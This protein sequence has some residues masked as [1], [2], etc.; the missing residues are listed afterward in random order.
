MEGR[1]GSKPAFK[2]LYVAGVAAFAAVA[3]CTG[4]SN[5]PQVGNSQ[6]AHHQPTAIVEP[7][8]H[9]T[10]QGGSGSAAGA[11]VSGAQSANAQAATGI[12]GCDSGVAQ[13]IARNALM[14]HLRYS[15]GAMCF[16]QNDYDDNRDAV[17]R[18]GFRPDPLGKSLDDC[19]EA[20]NG[21]DFV[22]VR[23]FTFE[24][25]D[26][27]VE[28]EY[29]AP[30]GRSV[31]CELSTAYATGSNERAEFAGPGIVRRMTIK[32]AGPTASGDWRYGAEVHRN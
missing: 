2:A 31:T 5:S 4:A 26:Y 7:T 20:P 17:G 3:G 15:E 18:A 6:P 10:A 27:L 21:R 32:Y 19:K 23:D 24:L 25:V 22:P 29:V 8:A 9:G 16:M 13:Y 28:G 30:D 14:E 1:S 12:P 11:Q